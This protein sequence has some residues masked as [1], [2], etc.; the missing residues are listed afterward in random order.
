VFW[1]VFAWVMHPERRL[2]SQYTAAA[3]EPQDAGTFRLIRLGNSMAMF[4]AFLLS[5]LPWAAVPWPRVAFIAGTAFVLAGGILRRVC[6]SVLGPYFTG[7][8]MVKKDQPVIDRGPYRWI[9]HPSYTAG[10]L[11]LCGI[12]V[13]LANW[14][15]ITVTVL[16]PCLIYK[17][18]VRAEERALLETIGEPYRRYM[19]R[20][21]RFIPFL[22]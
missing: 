20:T 18:R 21:K 11:L 10:L 3:A 19:S 14:L 7:V 16:V 5:F 15:S 9:R 17:Q 22:W 8:V 4:S 13:A 2:M 6:F 12:G 1:I